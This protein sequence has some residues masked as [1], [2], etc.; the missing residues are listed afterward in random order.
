MTRHHARPPKGRQLSSHARRRLSEEGKRLLRRALSHDFDEGDEPRYGGGGHHKLGSEDLS[1]VSNFDDSSAGS[2]LESFQEWQAQVTPVDEVTAVGGSGKKKGKAQRH[3][4]H[5]SAETA[6][7]HDELEEAME[8]LTEKRDTTKIAALQRI[9]TILCST[10]LTDRIQSNKLEL[11]SHA[12]NTLKKRMKDSGALSLRVLGVLAITIGPDEQEFYEEILQPLQRLVTDDCEPA[13]RIEAVYALSIACAVC[14]REDQQ[15][16]ELIDVL[17]SLLVEA[18]DADDN[19]DVEDVFS[20]DFLVAVMECWAFLLS[21]FRA[22]SI[23]SK[24]QDPDAVIFEH[25]EALAALVRE[26]MNP[27]IRSAAC[28]V[29]ALLIQ[30][31]YVVNKSS[32]WSYELEEPS[33][34]LAGLDSKIERFMR[35]TGKNIGKK[36]RKTQRSMLKEVLETLR[37]GEGPHKDLQIESETLSV[38][39]WNRFFQANVFRRAL[40]SGFQVHLY[41]NPVLRDVFEVSDNVNAKVSMIS[42]VR[43]RA[44]HRAKT[45]NKRN[46]ISRKGAAQNAFLYED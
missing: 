14:G 38:S 44:D 17:G 29:L 41:E 35:E 46:D 11:T 20:E 26:G 22:T 40:Q 30:M 9:L 24:L 45:I 4:G 5:T 27:G 16:W 37:T 6:D 36:N 25:V 33:S 43:R 2:D 7:G 21:A 12:L 13:L 18:R 32:S 10:V 15:K 19:G 23:V 34:P 3:K 8:Q 28:E 31:K 42:T 1:V 39:T